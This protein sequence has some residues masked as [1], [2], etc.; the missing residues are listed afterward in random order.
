V[1]AP[2]FAAWPAYVDRLRRPTLAQPPTLN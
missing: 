2:A 1:F